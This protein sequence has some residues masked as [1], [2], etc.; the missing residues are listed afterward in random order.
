MGDSE[1]PFPSG[2]RIPLFRISILLDELAQRLGKSSDIEVYEE[3][4]LGTFRALWLKPDFGVAIVLEQSDHLTNV[5]TFGERAHKGP[6]VYIDA[7]DAITN[8]YEYL[9]WG[10]IQALGIS[11]ANIEAQYSEKAQWLEQLAATRIVTE[12]AM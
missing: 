5:A 12:D 11:E 3:D 2:E 1:V 7:Y 4:G 9:Y 10:V 8:G 6:V